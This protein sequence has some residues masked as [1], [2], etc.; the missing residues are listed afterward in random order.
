MAKS[1]PNSHRQL[2]RPGAGRGPFFDFSSEEQELEKRNLVMYKRLIMLLGIFLG[3]H[4]PVIAQTAAPEII[5]AQDHV[6]PIITT[7]RTVSAPSLNASFLLKQ[8]PAKS[9][10]RFTNIFAGASK[11]EYG[12]ESLPPTDKVK[13]LLFTQSSLALIQLWSGRLQLDAF[14]NTLRVQN[15]ELDPLGYGGA[16]DRHPRKTY[17]GNPR[18]VDLSGISLSFHFGRDARTERPTQGWRRMS[19]IVA[20]VLY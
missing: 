18:S 1:G 20:N 3:S 9:P 6:A 13:T 14:Q 5:V 7:F 19:R 16:L 15:V 4:A 2:R 10:G 8:D 11:R 12:M 17:P